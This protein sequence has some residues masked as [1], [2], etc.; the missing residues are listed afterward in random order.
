MIHVKYVLFPGCT[1]LAKDPSFEA[2]AAKVFN[3]LDINIAQ[4]PRFHCCAPTIVASVQEIT[5]TA[6]AARNICLA[7]ERDLDIVTLCSGCFKNLKKVNMHLKH[8]P[9]LKKAVNEILKGIGKEFQGTI[10]IKHFVQVLLEDVGLEKIKEKIKRP[11]TDMVFASFY[12]CHLIRPHEVVEFDDPEIP[13]S[14][15]KIIEILGAKSLEYEGKYTCCGGGLKGIDDDAALEIP[16]QKL[17]ELKALDVDGLVLAC[18]TCYFQFDLGQFDIQRKFKE[19]YQVAP[20]HLTD[21]L[22]IAFGIDVKTLGLDLH[23]IKPQK[24]LSKIK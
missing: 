8:D 13:R 19:Q 15:D 16:R 3:V 22:G 10:K 6:L 5:A 21:I 4:E 12:G 24:F 1:V 17:I 7:E 20:L 14:I 9:A 2:S 23:R 18:P 11:L